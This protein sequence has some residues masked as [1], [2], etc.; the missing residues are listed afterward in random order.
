[1]CETATDRIET[2]HRPDQKGGQQ[3][4]GCWPLVQSSMCAC[5]CVCVC[6]C[7][8]NMMQRRGCTR[9]CSSGGKRRG[10]TRRKQQRPRRGNKRTHCARGTGTACA[11]P[12]GALSKTRGGSSLKRPPPPTTTYHHTTTPPHH[13]HTTTPPHRHGD[14]TPPPPPPPPP[15]IG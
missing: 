6:V 3:H 15:P 9:T 1:M 4:D 12:M 7:V 5:V 13:H 8:C 14:H 11:T 10:R 2:A